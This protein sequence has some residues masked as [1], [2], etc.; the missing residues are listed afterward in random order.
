MKKRGFLKQISAI[1][2]SKKLQRLNLILILSGAFLVIVHSSPSPSKPLTIPLISDTPALDLYTQRGGYGPGEPSGDFA[3]GEIVELTALLTYNGAPVEYKPVGFEVRDATGGIVLIRSNMT[4]ANGLARINFTIRGDCVKE[5]FGTWTVFA[6]ASVSQQTVN[7]TLT[8]RVSGPFLDIYTQKPDPYS[9]KG[10][11][12]ASDA[13]APQEEVILYGEAHY[14]CERIEYKFV[15]FEIRDPNGRAIDYRVNATNQDGIAMTSFRLASNATFG[16]Y[17]VFGTVEILGRIANDTL[18]FRVGWII[19]ISTL[20]IVNASG[21]PQTTF[22]RG[23]NVCFNVTAKNIAFVSKTVTFTIAALDVNGAPVGQI[24]LPYWEIPSGTSVIFLASV[25]IPE[26][27]YI[28]VALAFAN[29]YTHLPITSG[30]PY[31][32]EVSA[33]FTIVP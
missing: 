5:I 32:P 9:G 17:T 23:E 20:N 27:T 2:E 14:D 30:V 8:F 29:A 19:E 22:A 24:V 3:P 26:W 33:V 31:C 13:F 16:T 18:T 12:R 28:G 6:I 11:D 1:L 25:Q 7:D 21:E 4:D 10:L 15:A